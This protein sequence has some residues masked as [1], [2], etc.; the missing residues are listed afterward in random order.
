M[1]V[2][3]SNDA[4]RGGADARRLRGR[5]G[6]ARSS[7]LPYLFI[8][9][10]IAN[11]ASFVL[12][13]SNPANLVVFG[14]HMPPLTRWLRASSPCRR[15]LAIVATYAVLRLTQRRALREPESRTDV[16]AAAAL[17]A[18]A[19][20]AALGIVATAVVLIGASALRARSRPADL[21]RRR[22]PR[23]RRAG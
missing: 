1:T 10:F 2:F 17:A 20:V 4:M 16:D 6:R 22:S 9:A 19:S 18:A 5:Q 21:H 23:A 15:S 13:I 8:C 12:P 11:A 14:E 3:L 7:R